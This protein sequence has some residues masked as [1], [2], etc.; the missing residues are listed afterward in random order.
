MLPTLQ[1]PLATFFP[2]FKKV[3]SGKSLGFAQTL[4]SFWDSL[5]MPREHFR[6]GYLALS[7]KHRYY[8]ASSRP[9]IIWVSSG[10]QSANHL[11]QIGTAER[12]S[13]IIESVRDSGARSFE[14]V[15]DRGARIANHLSQIGSAERDHWVSSGT[16]ERESFESDRDGGA[17]IIWVS[18][19]R[20][21]ANHLSQFGTSGARI[22]WVRSGPR[23]ANHLSQFG[24]A[25]RE[26]FES[27]R[28]H[29]SFLSVR[30]RRSLWYGLI[31]LIFAVWRQSERSWMQHWAA[32]DQIT[33]R[34]VKGSLGACCWSSLSVL[35]LLFLQSVLYSSTNEACVCRVLIFMLILNGISGAQLL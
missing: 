25:E 1:T 28:D 22:I 19:G 29:E 31:W 23:S 15:R 34:V 3:P 24:T 14:S 16:A 21:S 33:H 10:P 5:V 35:Y 17:R 7:V 20:R 30:D 18:S 13:R 32:R 6:Y 8:V 26:S 27:V 12:E 11:S 2:L 9:R 4:F